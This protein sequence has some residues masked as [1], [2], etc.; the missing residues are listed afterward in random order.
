MYFV[1]TD[2]GNVAFLGYEVRWK[3]WDNSPR[4]EKVFSLSQSLFCCPSGCVGHFERLKYV[5]HISSSVSVMRLNVGRRVQNPLTL[6][7]VNRLLF[8]KVDAFLVGSHLLRLKG[9]EKGFLFG[10]FPYP[11]KALALVGS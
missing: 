9:L 3:G 8:P 6:P 11:K 4:L 1:I 2:I 5:G 10:L 7:F